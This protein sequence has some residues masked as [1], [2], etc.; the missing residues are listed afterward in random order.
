MSTGG[1]HGTIRLRP[2]NPKQLASS[3]RLPSGR[4]PLSPKAG[5]TVGSDLFP[6]DQKLIIPRER[7]SLASH[8]VL[9]EVVDVELRPDQCLSTG[10]PL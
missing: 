10:S 4:E 7:D 5:F 1:H 2:R 6:D 9:V 3:E 8:N